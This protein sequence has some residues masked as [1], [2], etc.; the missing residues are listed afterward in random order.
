LRTLHRLLLHHL[1][2]QKTEKD[3]TRVTSQ[4]DVSDDSF[5][6]KTEHT[7]NVMSIEHPEFTE[8]VRH[9]GSHS[10]ILSIQNLEIDT[11]LEETSIKQR[12]ARLHKSIGH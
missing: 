6:R 10:G 9:P 8:N 11:V 3:S 4:C 2:K 5:N 1:A 12:S 7:E